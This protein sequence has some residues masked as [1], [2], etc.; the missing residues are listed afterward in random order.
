MS[1]RVWYMS[2]MFVFLLRI[3]M[4]CVS[5]LLQKVFMA[6][7]SCCFHLSIVLGGRCLLTL[8]IGSNLF[9]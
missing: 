7:T 3:G 5:V 8:N 1:S 9:S 4:F 2:L 6:I